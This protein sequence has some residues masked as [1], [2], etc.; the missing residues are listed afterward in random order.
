MFR[1]EE[2]QLHI[3]TGLVLIATVLSFCLLGINRSFG[4][5]STGRLQEMSDFS[6]GW[7]CTYRTNDLNRLEEYH[8]A[9]GG[10]FA[11]DDRNLQEVNTFPAVLPVEKNQPVV[12][13]HIAPETGRESQYLLFQTDGQHIQVSVDE[14]VIYQS[15][16]K[17]SGVTAYHL[18]P[19][20]AEYNDAVIKVQI[21][22][23]PDGRV[24]INPIYTGTKNQLIVHLLVRDGIMV[25]VGL[26]LVGA[27]VFCLLI[28]GLLQN[29][30]SQ[31]RLLLYVILEG[32]GFGLLF[33]LKGRT[34]AV[35]S[36]LNYGLW[37]LRACLCILTGILNLMVIRCFV[38]RK[39][40]LTFLDTGILIYLV[41][42]ISVMVL[43]GFSL[44][45]F[46]TA[47]YIGCGMFIVCHAICTVVLGT[48]LSRYRQK[49]C[50]IPLTGSVI[51]LLCAAMQFVAV[52]FHLQQDM[53]NMWYL[54]SGLIIYEG[55]M[56][57]VGLKQALRLWPEKTEEPDN[58]DEI[59]AQLI[60]R[61][62]PNLIFAALHSLQNLIA[63]GSE[64]SIKMLYYISVYL[65]NNLNALQKAGE[66]IP[67]EEELEHII[68]YLQ[69]QKMRNIGLSFRFECKIKAFQIPRHT[70]EPI[71]ENAVKYGISGKDNKG[72]VVIRTYLRAEGYA[73]Q[74]IDDGIGFDKEQLTRKSPTALLNL[75]DQL[76]VIC[77]ARTEIISKSGKGTVVTI[78][79]PMLEND[80]MDD[81]ENMEAAD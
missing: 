18:I 15:S 55:F 31:K 35:L 64:N 53:Q 3:L 63:A 21:S 30:W 28:Y 26:I 42:Y 38:R 81:E 16:D 76:K 19:L 78:V 51:I 80:I 8:N 73:V 25:I 45:N 37:L 4:R 27:A 54:M 6:D 46:S 2:R 47:Y 72:N 20:S 17:E 58:E 12:F 13:F 5:N 29:T 65:R 59:K 71:V 75:L 44:I 32:L 36:G 39:K 24:K 52:L 70:L 56:L 57:F 67:F 34:M 68:A 48:A 49:D 74:I 7:I 60:E 69:L 50:V 23:N 40:M 10:D 1:L 62:N 14:K 61:L 11:A 41:F 79:L 9:E 66:M 22:G 77:D 43:Q 33:L